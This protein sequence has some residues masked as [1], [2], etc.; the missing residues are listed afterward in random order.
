MCSR[1]SSRQ[2]L[3]VEVDDLDA[4]DGDAAAVGL[5]EPGEDVHEG[6]LA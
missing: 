3:V 6:G 5:V 4:G 1:R 2:P